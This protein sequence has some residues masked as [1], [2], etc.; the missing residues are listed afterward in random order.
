MKFTLKNRTADSQKAGCT[1][2]SKCAD[3]KTEG[4]SSNDSG[5]CSRYQTCET[6]CVSATQFK[7]KKSS[8]MNMPYFFLSVYK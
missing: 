8:K 1:D 5:S 4:Y 2:T 7:S 6:R 3:H